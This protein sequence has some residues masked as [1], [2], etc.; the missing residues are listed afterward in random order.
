MIFSVWFSKKGF[1]VIKNDA[2]KERN[3]KAGERYKKEYALVDEISR[4]KRTTENEQALGRTR[5]LHH[6][7]TFFIVTKDPISESLFVKQTKKN[8]VQMSSL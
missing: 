4:W 1:I 8:K 2:R 5:F 7:V 3:N 6:D